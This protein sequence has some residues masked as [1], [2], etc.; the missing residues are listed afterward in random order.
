[1]RPGHAST[2]PLAITQIRRKAE[3][4]FRRKCKIDFRCG[5]ENQQ[6]RNSVQR[7]SD[8]VGI[9]RAGRFLA[10]GFLEDGPVRRLWHS[11]FPLKK[12][13]IEIS[14]RKSRCRQSVAFGSIAE[15]GDDPVTAKSLSQFRTR[16]SRR[17]RDTC[18]GWRGLFFRDR[19]L[20]WGQVPSAV[21]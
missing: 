6:D 11:S 21:C 16:R 1:M 4:H 7:M 17:R 12:G 14:F 10:R 9:Q 8:P 19:G 13:S 3:K 20:A 15:Q 18:Q 2:C 5:Q